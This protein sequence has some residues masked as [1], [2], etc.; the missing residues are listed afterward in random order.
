M[1]RAKAHRV[2]AVGLAKSGHRSEAIGV[3]NDDLQDANIRNPDESL[4]FGVLLAEH[5]QLQGDFKAARDVYDLLAS[6]LFRITS[7]NVCYT[8]LL[9]FTRL[10]GA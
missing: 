5:F 3:F 8:K 1:L 2:V 6:R 9:R 10:D 7:Y 4:D